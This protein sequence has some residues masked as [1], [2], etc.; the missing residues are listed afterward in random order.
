[1]SVTTPSREPVT[2]EPAMVEITPFAVDDFAP[3]PVL[4]GAGGI[5]NSALEGRSEPVVPARVGRSRARQAVK[6]MDAA[7][8]APASVVI[9]E[10]PLPAPGSFV[11]DSEVAARVSA[12]PEAGTG[13]GQVS[14]LTATP[15]TVSITPDTL[16]PDALE[17]DLP[18]AQPEDAD[19]DASGEPR[20]RRRRSSA[21]D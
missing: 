21:S 7:E 14:L 1:M 9:Q 10:S 3:I 13:L 8:L 18:A 15:L 12:A 2:R 6:S 5:D 4:V 11:A 19:V 16:P 20:R 17:V